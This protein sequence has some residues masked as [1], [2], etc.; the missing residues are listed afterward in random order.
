[1][2]SHNLQKT[3]SLLFLVY[4]RSADEKGK[5]QSPFPYWDPETQ[6]WALLNAWS[7]QLQYKS[8]PLMNALSIC[9][10]GATCAEASM[11]VYINDSYNAVVSTHGS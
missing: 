5:F 10:W 3:L 9:G 8:S 7:T 1:M 6:L 2:A 4:T 11:T